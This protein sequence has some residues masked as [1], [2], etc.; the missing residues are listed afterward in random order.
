MPMCSEY[1]KSIN[2]SHSRPY[3][4]ESEIERV[5]DVI[6]SGRIAQGEMV[7]QF[8][9]VFSLKFNF[10]HTAATNSGTSALHLALLAIGVKPGDEVI[11]PSY[12]CSALL[13]AV[14]CAG[15]VSVIADID[16]KT[17]NID[18][19]DMKKRITGKTRAIIAP[20]MFGLS[21][22]MEQLLEFDIPII[23]DCAQSVGGE[24]NGRPVGSFGKASIFSFYATKV[25]TT[26]EGGMV[27]SG[28]EELIDRIMDLREY[29]NKSDDK[30]RYNYKMSDVH[31]AIGLAQ[32]DRLDSFIKKRREIAACYTDAFKFFDFQLP[33][34]DSGHIFFRYVIGLKKGEDLDHWID[35]LQKRGVQCAR[36]V[37]R[38]IHKILGL[39]GYKQ[40]NTVW[41]Q[42]LSI[43]IYPLL[44]RKEVDYIIASVTE[45]YH[46]LM[47]E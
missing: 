42:L 23:E 9:Q 45:T 10:S 46:E 25:M 22:D 47:G 14:R 33:A 29:D 3:L 4:G 35:V 41:G 32:I 40:T 44:A 5:T 19:K 1:L 11:I 2:I 13:H 36:P 8:E 34:M 20:H 24:Y 17:Y 12:V 15:A 37:F 39:S 30:Q 43:P 6:S 16:P 7:R 31:A 38:P 18:P 28:S 26:A 21:A 27:S